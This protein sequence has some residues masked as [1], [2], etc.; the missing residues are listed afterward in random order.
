MCAALTIASGSFFLGQ[1]EHHASL[2]AGIAVALRVNDRVLAVDGLPADP[3]ATH[4]MVQ[5]SEI[6]TWEDRPAVFPSKTM[7]MSLTAAFLKWP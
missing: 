2:H 1:V 5:E 4:A 3:R 7:S 6:P